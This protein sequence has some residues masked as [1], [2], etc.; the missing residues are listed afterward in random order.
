MSQEANSKVG[1]T[2]AVLVFVVVLALIGV[3]LV[4]RDLLHRSAAPVATP[5]AGAPTATG[6]VQALQL[7][8]APTLLA[9]TATPTPLPTATFIVVTPPPPP[10]NVFEAATR[11]AEATAQ[12]EQFGTPTPLPAHFV[13]ATPTPKRTVVTPTPTAANSATVEHRAALATAIAFTTG[14]PEPL[15]DNVLVATA[16]A[17]PVFVPIAGTPA[18]PAPTPTPIFP[19]DLVG[20]ILFRSN[21]FGSDT[22]P[23]A[24]D[25]DGAGLARLTAD[26]PIGRAAARE[27]RS[28]D[29]R[30]RARIARDPETGQQRLFYSQDASDDQIPLA[31]LGG[32]SAAA[33]SP[34]ADLIAFSAP[35]G[36]S[37]KIWV[38]AREG[39]EPLQLTA[40]AGQTDQRP[41]WSPDGR[42][43]VFT[44]NRTG[45]RQLWIMNADGSEQRLLFEADYEAWDPVWVKYAE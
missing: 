8:Q 36:G 29:G 22:Q 12:A 15:P 14:T 45:K 33:W 1:S 20:K 25:P 38:V 13:T 41:T 31:A 30:Y 6:N 19:A 27:T 9:Y 10:A 43:I 28:A 23:Y 4:A 37:E 18:A 26:W 40:N 2:R 32:V 17:T 35:A 44:S 34:V 21:M 42:Q 5:A 16:T 3:A 39:G 11:A 7:V 24:I